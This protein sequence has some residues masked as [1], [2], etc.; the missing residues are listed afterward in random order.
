M[1]QPL[2]EPLIKSINLPPL[3]S[4]VTRPRDATG[5][6]SLQ[7]AMNTIPPFD[8][9]P[10]S[11]AFFCRVVRNVLN[12]FGSSAECWL[13]SALASKF[14]G[15]AVEGYMCRM[16][17]FTSVEKVLEDITMRYT[18]S[19]GADRLLAELKVVKQESGES[20]GSYG[21]RVEILLNRLLN[22]YDADR[23]LRD[24]ERLTYKNR[25]DSEALEQF[26]YGLQGDLK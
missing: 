14:R 19:R 4:R 6:F 26:L 8:G 23:S 20:V 5:T 24:F 2:D 22:T 3:H 11:V 12:E 17:Q 1:R 18:H 16:N 25:G 9:N 21:Q 10:D 15:P 13:M 7:Q